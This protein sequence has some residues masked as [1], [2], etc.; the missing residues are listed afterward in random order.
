MFHLIL[1]LLSWSQDPQNEQADAEQQSSIA[2]EQAEQLAKDKRKSQALYI[3]AKK[4][5]ENAEYQ[6]AIRAFEMIL[7]IDPNPKILKELSSAHQFLSQYNEAILYLSQ[8]KE[9]APEE[10]KG[11]IETKLSRLRSLK[12][13]SRGLSAQNVELPSSTNQADLPNS[14][15]KWQRGSAIAVAILGAGT[16]GYFQYQAFH[17]RDQIEVSCH[18]VGGRLLCPKAQTESLFQAEAQA[19]LISGIGWGV[20]AAGILTDT[21]LEI[22]YGSFLS[23]SPN[24]VSFQGVF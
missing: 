18:S 5:Y 7:E 23:V 3:T 16:G 2:Q 9:I 13:K 21:F 19:N 4:L 24:T 8:Y 6:D 1:P 12:E 14:P 15:A 11:A 22:K 20:C 10:E 17:N